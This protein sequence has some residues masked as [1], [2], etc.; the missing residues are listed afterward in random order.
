M[1]DYTLTL[2]NYRSFPDSSPLRFELRKGFTGFVGPNNSGKS[3]ILRFFYEAR[4]L[5]QF[6]NEPLVNHLSAI[7]GQGQGFGSWLLPPGEELFNKSNERDLEFVISWRAKPAWGGATEEPHSV[8]LHVPR[9]S[10]SFT[11]MLNA[12]G[13]Q[14]RGTPR[15]SSNRAT[16]VQTDTHDFMDLQ[17]LYDLFAILKRSIYVGPFRNVVNLGGSQSYFDVAIGDQFIAAFQNMKAGAQASSNEAVY[18]LISDI[19]RIF[20]FDEFDINATPDGQSLQAFVNGRSFRLTELG[21]GIAHFILVLA[22]ALTKR[23]SF[24]LLD[25]P[26]LNLHASLQLDFLTTTAAYTSHGVLFATHSLGLARAASQTVYAVRRVTTGVS[27]VRPY[28]DLPALSEFVGEINFSAYRELGFEKLLLVEG[29]SDVTAIQQLL[30]LYGKEHQ[31]AMI[32]LGGASTISAGGEVQLTELARITPHLH[33]LVDSER[34]QEGAAPASNVEAFRDLCTRAGVAIHVLERRALEN[35][36]TDR[37]VKAAFGSSFAGLQ[38]FERLSDLAQI[39]PKKEN[40][41]VARHMTKQE[42]DATD[43]GAFL[44]TL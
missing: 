28:E 7:Q 37:A 11:M 38:P 14:F 32:H 27:E 24:I 4:Q 25:E 44:G 29:P 40:W 6:F 22:N 5:F 30:R 13:D 42:L 19:R 35:Y 15:F 10:T 3:S 39:W 17:P 16:M 2:K 33:A 1:L 31:I 8:T 18:R 26:E 12:A 23:P 9:A 41:R 34:G 36:F 21:G 20:E 43:L